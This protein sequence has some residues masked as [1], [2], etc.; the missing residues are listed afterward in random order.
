MESIASTS[1]DDPCISEN[2]HRITSTIQESKQTTGGIFT[3]CHCSL[4]ERFDFKGIKP[5]FARQLTYM[6][7]CYI[8]K[9]PFSLPNK[10]EVLVL[11]ADCNFCKKPACLGCSIY[12]GKRFCL[13]C[14]SDNIC[15][16]PSQLQPKIKS[17]I[18]NI[19]S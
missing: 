16:L 8:M 9:D 12:F 2:N 4:Q 6:E 5:P 13:K 19:N 3:C 18:K 1:T 10:G 15:N 7:E 11:G 14:A 17:L